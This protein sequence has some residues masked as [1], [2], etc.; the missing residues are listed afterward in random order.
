ML[1]TSCIQGNA[2]GNAHRLR[3]FDCGVERFKK[4]LGIAKGTVIIYLGKITQMKNYDFRETGIYKKA[5]QQA[6][7][8]FELTKSFPAVEKYSLIDQIRRSSRSVCANYAEG[9]RKRRYPAHLIAK[10]SDCDMENT[11]TR[12]WLDFSLSCK[13]ISSEQYT[14]YVELNSE[15]GKLLGHALQRPELY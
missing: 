4:Y 10:L 13:Y 9:Q 8:I 6:M 1:R 11:E 5:F 15:V 7:E 12:V 3:Q 2:R 14:Y